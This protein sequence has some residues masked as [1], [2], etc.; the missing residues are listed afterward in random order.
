MLNKGD[1]FGHNE[2]ANS[3]PWPFDVTSNTMSKLLYL[4]KTQF[5][6]MFTTEISSSRRSKMDIAKDNSEI[7][8][9]LL[10]YAKSCYFKSIL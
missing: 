1:F 7:S 8:K 10:D 5:M 4:N 2:I 9:F 6:N 3:L